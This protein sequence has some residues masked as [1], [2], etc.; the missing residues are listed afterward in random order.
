VAVDLLR[1]GGFAMW[2]RI[3]LFLLLLLVGIVLGAC[4]AAQQRGVQAQQVPADVQTQIDAARGQF[5]DAY[6]RQDAKALSELFAE[7]GA[8][9]GTISTVWIEGREA[10][11]ANWERLFRAFPKS[12]IVFRNP[13][14]RL[15]NVPPRGAAV[16]TTVVVETGFFD[17]FM[18]DPKG[19]VQHTPGKY[20]AMRVKKD[21]RWMLVNFQSA[22]LPVSR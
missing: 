14:I 17:M 8:F 6:Q 5:M 19:Q 11:R 4:A 13:L 1:E 20:S 7:D 2:K 15:Y 3:Q 9:T 18:E 21:G 10:I 22:G 16:D 12:R